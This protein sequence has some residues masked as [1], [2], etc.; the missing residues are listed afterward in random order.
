MILA[1]TSWTQS[2]AESVRATRSAMPPGV[3]SRCD[4]LQVERPI[5]LS[6]PP[7]SA[8][9][10]LRH[11]KFQICRAGRSCGDGLLRTVDVGFSLG[12]LFR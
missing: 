3:S 1:R 11:V 2:R 5:P 12:C 4:R 10:G 8:P 6:R 7:G 9:K